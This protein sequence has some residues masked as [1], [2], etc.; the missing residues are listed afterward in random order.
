MAK[1]SGIV[2]DII[3]YESLIQFQTVKLNTK[4]EITNFLLRGWDGSLHWSLF[5]NYKKI[6]LI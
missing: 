3:H 4:L 1:P 5:K 2:S 6:F